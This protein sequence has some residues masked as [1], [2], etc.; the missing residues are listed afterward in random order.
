MERRLGRKIV[1][2]EVKLL[3]KLMI[4]PDFENGSIYLDFSFEKSVPVP[5][6]FQMPVEYFG[7]LTKSSMGTLKVV[8]DRLKGEQV[9]ELKEKLEDARKEKQ[10]LANEFDEARE[11]IE[12]LKEEL[13]SVQGDLESEKERSDEA[14]SEKEEIE[15]KL[16]ERKEEIESLRME[17]EE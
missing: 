10:E 15:E 5:P 13:E 8:K 16:E 12:S 9:N 17:L 14:I 1:L 4:L 2:K 11:E 7:N 3:K 6:L